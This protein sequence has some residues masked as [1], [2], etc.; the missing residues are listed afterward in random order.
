MVA[1]SCPSAS[2][3]VA[4]D[5]SGDVFAS[6]NPG[7]GIWRQTAHVAVPG[8]GSQPKAIACPSTRLCVM[9]AD[10]GLVFTSTNPG[11]SGASWKRAHVDTLPQP[12]TP[13]GLNGLD[14]ISC[15]SARQCIAVDAAGYAFSSVNPTGG[16]GAWHVN[17][18]D[19]LPRRLGGNLNG[20]SCPTARLC[21]AVDDKGAMSSTDPMRG[22]SAWHR[23]GLHRRNVDN[24]HTVSCPSARLCV[25]LAG[26]SRVL[27]STRPTGGARAWKA[28]HVPFG[29]YSSLSC[30][31]VRLCVAATYLGK[32]VSSTRPTGGTRAWR[33]ADL[34]G[35]SFSPQMVSCPSSAL[36]VAVGSQSAVSS[37]NPTG[38]SGAWRS[39]GLYYPVVTP[40]TLNGIACATAQLCVAVDDGGSVISSNNP[41][42]GQTAWT[43]Q[44]ADSVALNAVSCTSAPLCV[45]VDS[46]GAVSFPATRPALPRCGAAP[47]STPAI[48]SSRCR[49]RR[50]SC[51]LRQ[52]TPATW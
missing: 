20:I 49:V 48:S 45:A 17:R 51:A 34:G 38:G 11:V 10:G 35:P 42:G 39:V 2:L 15:P 29:S 6:S 27:T 8:L 13:P 30:P 3:C 52:T 43:R 31:S 46:A 24:L 28:V 50:S 9:T 18:I 47:W 21:V 1:V 41:T 4:V 7:I 23:V 19:P 44:T 37:V 26:T 5:D 33:R 40:P 25:I 36:C 12:R 16:R 32:V 22:L 14:A